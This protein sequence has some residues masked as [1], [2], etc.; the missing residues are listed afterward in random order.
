MKRLDFRRINASI[1]ACPIAS[2]GLMSPVVLADENEEVVKLY[3]QGNLVK[4]LEQADAYLATKPKDAQM[5]FSKGLILTEQKKTGD[6]IKVFLPYQRIILTCLNH[7]IILQCSTPAR[8]SMT[9]PRARLRQRY[10]LTPAIPLPM[11]IWVTFTQ[12][13]PARRMARLFN[14]ITGMPPHRPSSR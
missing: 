4:A 7:T 10:A 6:A 12:R 2:L 5:R 11:K 13:W 8:A 14:W 3:Q 9:K 1:A